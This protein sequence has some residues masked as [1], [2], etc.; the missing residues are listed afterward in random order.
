M[1][2]LPPL[3]FSVCTSASVYVSFSQTYIRERLK[4]V[5]IKRM[6][7]ISV[8]YNLPFSHTHAHTHIPMAASYSA[9][10]CP[11]C[12]GQFDFSGSRTV[13]HVFRRSQGSHHH[14]QLVGDPLCLPNCQG[15][16]K[17]LAWGHYCSKDLLQPVSGVSV[18]PVQSYG[19]V[20]LIVCTSKLELN[21]YVCSYVTH[22]A[23]VI[24]RCVVSL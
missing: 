21:L 10:H 11:C 14:L 6:F 13:G 24:L 1:Y 12:L 15:G 8:F 5:I 16:K 4:N 2:C 22:R 3:P 7:F 17:R 19:S 20:H 18:M 23:L 9:R